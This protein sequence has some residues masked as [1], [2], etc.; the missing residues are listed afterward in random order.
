MLVTGDQV[1]AIDAATRRNLELIQALDGSRSTSLLGVLDRTVTGAGASLLT[2][3]LSA[4]S[5]DPDAIAA[6]HDAVALL[7]R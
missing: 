7:C 2:A 4:P 3:R 1:M 5:T 6:R